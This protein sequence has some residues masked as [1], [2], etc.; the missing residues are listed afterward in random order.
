MPIEIVELNHVN[1]RVPASQEAAAKHFYASVLGLTEVPKPAELKD[2]GGAWYQIGDTQLHLSRD[3]QP[4]NQISK[5]HICY[6]VTDLAEAKRQLSNA[7]V[8][9]IPDD[10]PVQGCQ[11]FYVRDPGGNL[12]ELAQGLN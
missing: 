5:Q 10:L 1:V 2:R 9:I 7:G 8:E 12:I 4:D 6:L 11:R 3:D